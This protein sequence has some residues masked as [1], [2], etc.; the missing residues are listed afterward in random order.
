MSP[1]SATAFR[2]GVSSSHCESV[3]SL[4]YPHIETND[5]V[6]KPQYIKSHQVEV[7]SLTLPKTLFALLVLTSIHV[8]LAFLSTY[9][10]SY[11]PGEQK[12]RDYRWTLDPNK[13]RF[14]TAKGGTVPAFNGVSAG[15]TDRG[16]HVDQ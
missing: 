5:N 11:E 9:I 10:Q 1:L 16:R 2:F 14:G 13:Y 7:E 8:P 6:F 15:K 3:K 12:R 4:L